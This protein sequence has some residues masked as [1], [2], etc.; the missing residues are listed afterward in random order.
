MTV[1]AR[2]LGKRPVTVFVRAHKATYLFNPLF[3]LGLVGYSF[4][5]LGE[6]Y[7]GVSVR[8][9]N[10]RLHHDPNLNPTVIL[11]LTLTLAQPLTLNP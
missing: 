11:N 3:H 7:V 4:S 5:F 8:Q 2:C 9:S 6:R 10:A 1:Q